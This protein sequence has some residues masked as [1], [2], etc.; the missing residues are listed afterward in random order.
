[1]PSGQVPFRPISSQFWFIRNLMCLIFFSPVFYLLIRYLKFFG[2][3]LAAIPWLF[4]TDSFG[5]IHTY[6]L[7]FF[8]AGAWFALEKRNF[9]KD[10]APYMILS[11]I[12]V[13]LSAAWQIFCHVR[14]IPQI[15][16]VNKLGLCASVVFIIALSGRLIENGTLRVNIP[17]CKTSFFIF[18]FHLIPVGIVRMALSGYFVHTDFNL[19][20]SHLLNASLVTLSCI[21]IYK[22]LNRFTPR[23]LSFITGGR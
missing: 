23:F 5:N 6:T 9:V 7:F 14:Q 2:V 17:L 11:G 21:F 8:A 20:W 19:F 16:L 10:F 22:F 15:E 1:M 13:L 18:A 3:I 12:L 4:I